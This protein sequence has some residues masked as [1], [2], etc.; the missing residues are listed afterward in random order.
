MTTPHFHEGPVCPD[1]IAAGN[2]MTP[3][4]TDPLAALLREIDKA[5]V[6]LDALATEDPVV[7]PAAGWLAFN[8]RSAL[9]LLPAPT[10]TP[11]QSE[12]LRAALELV[13]TQHRRGDWTEDGFIGNSID[14][15][16]C[17]VCGLS[18]P[19]AAQALRA[20]LPAHPD[21]EETA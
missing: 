4:T 11:P 12:A 19:C 10:P 13:E 3:T 8:L 20:A 17:V 18:W 16:E 2:P 6:Y 15:R 7:H 9:D 21:T 5:L 14:G 1:C